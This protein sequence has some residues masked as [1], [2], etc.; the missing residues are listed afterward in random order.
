MSISPIPEPSNPGLSV[1]HE[2]KGLQLIA[3]HL[4]RESIGLGC[5]RPL[6][7]LQV[8]QQPID[9]QHISPPGICGDGL[10]LVMHGNGIRFVLAVMVDGGVE[11]NRLGRRKLVREK[12]AKYNVFGIPSLGCTALLIGVK[13]Y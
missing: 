2:L 7:G 10:Q 13:V 6:R 9:A 3:A 12:Q 8:G 5:R 4:N 11:W 1:E